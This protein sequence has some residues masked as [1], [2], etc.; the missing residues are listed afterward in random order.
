MEGFIFT[1]LFKMT[2]NYVHLNS[3]L[4]EFYHNVTASSKLI[5]I[6]SIKQNKIISSLNKQHINSLSNLISSNRISFQIVNF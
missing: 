4:Y 5:N 2:L 6:N 3:S 1:I